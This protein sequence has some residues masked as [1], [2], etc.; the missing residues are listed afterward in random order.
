MTRIC[1]LEQIGMCASA[2]E[3]DQA[4]LRAVI[5]FVRQQKVA[6]DMAF[7]VSCPSRRPKH[8]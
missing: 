6:A 1:L 3:D 2:H 7:A 8:C 4:M 5:E